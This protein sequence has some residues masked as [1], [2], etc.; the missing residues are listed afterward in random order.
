MTENNK[1]VL[2]LYKN[3]WNEIKYRIKTINSGES[4]FI[5]YENDI[6]K[7]ILNLHDDTP[8]NKILSFFVLNMLCKSVFQIE[9]KYYS[10]FQL[11][12]ECEYEREDLFL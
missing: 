2:E 11:I 3:L 6:M 7:I 9:N 4:N 12:G 10:Q 8:L 5:E 1:E